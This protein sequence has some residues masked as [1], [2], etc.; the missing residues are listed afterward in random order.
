[1]AERVVLVTGA[2][3]A[4]GPSV[5]RACRAAGYSVRTLSVDSPDGAVLP[6]GVD[7]RV[8]DVCDVRTVRA[9]VAGVD[10]VIHLAALLHRFGN[11]AALGP[12]YER[13]N[14]GGTEN[15]VRA[16]IAESVRRVVFLSTIAVY[17]P[18]SGQLIDENTPPHPETPYGQ[19]KL[20]AEQAV[21]AATSGRQPIGTVLRA[22]DAYGPRVKG[23]YRRLAVM[24]ARR[25][26]VQVGPGANRR[27]L[28]FDRD[29]ANAA[30]L[31]AGHPAAAGA[32]FNVSDGQVHT[33]AEI[34]A[35]ICRAVGRHP[36]RFSVPLAAARVAIGACER[37]CQLAGVRPP[38]TRT[39]LDKY[40]EDVAVDATLI[41]R[42]L[43][44]VPS[45]DLDLGWRETMAGLRD[46]GAWSGMS[47]PSGAGIK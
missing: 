34:I 46:A 12:Q 11:S 37:G 22:A 20:A 4:V 8:G 9:A 7:V 23:N 5:V 15:V 3:G 26:F 21:L 36:P 10:V 28:V 27:T 19:T 17:G 24:I 45:V 25:R 2:T 31:A 30:V 6:L 1:M 13:I 39:L 29:L 38:V 42:V 40:T 35:A 47:A 14:V 33:L 18:S 41:Q 43:G 16:G 44:F 32:V